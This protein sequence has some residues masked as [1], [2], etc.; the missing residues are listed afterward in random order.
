MTDLWKHVMLGRPDDC[1]PWTGCR[2][3]KGYGLAGFT[4]GTVGA[5]R[6][7]Y[8]M[9]KGEI[10]PGMVVCHRCDNPPCCNP[11]HLFLG[12]HRD[13]V[14]DKIA[15]GRDNSPNGSRHWNSKLTEAQ[16]FAIYNDPRTQREIVADYGIS[17]G[18]VSQIKNGQGWRHVT[19]PTGSTY[20]EQLPAR[21]KLT[22]QFAS[23]WQELLRTRPTLNLPD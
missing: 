11:N 23:K 6:L 21:D 19:N 10:P 14:L 15:K 20:V 3:P 17:R 16:A 22:P 9:H 18:T 7:S 12:T 1:W 4:S 5:H 2:T 13:N 8:R